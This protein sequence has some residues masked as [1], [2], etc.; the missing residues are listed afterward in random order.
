MVKLCRPFHVPVE[1]WDSKVNCSGVGLMVYFLSP[2]LFVVKGGK[3]F[4]EARLL[5][6]FFL[7]HLL[8]LIYSYIYSLHV[9][10]CM[11]L[12]FMVKELYFKV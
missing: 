8:F 6:V 11:F 3:D 5:P 9:F 2:G 4:T 1:W 12:L 10:L 7:K